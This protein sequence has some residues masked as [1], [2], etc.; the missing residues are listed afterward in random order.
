MHKLS[1]SWIFGVPVTLP[2]VQEKLS[3]VVKLEKDK[4]PRRNISEVLNECHF[5]VNVNWSISLYFFFFF[6]FFQFHN[7]DISSH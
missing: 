7:P 4:K 1:S 5:Y 6:F 2:N 3:V